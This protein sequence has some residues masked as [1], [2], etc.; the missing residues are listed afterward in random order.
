MR[1]EI[2]VTDTERVPGDGSVAEVEIPMRD[3]F[4]VSFKLDP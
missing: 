4:A 1:R 3:E 2:G